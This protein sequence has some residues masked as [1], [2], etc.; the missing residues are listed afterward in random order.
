MTCQSCR[1]FDPH[2]AT[3]SPDFSRKCVTCDSGYYPSNGICV[4]CS[5]TCQQNKC[6]TANGMCMLCI[7]NYVVTSPISTNCIMCSARNKDCVT[8]A[9]NFTQKCVKCKNGK[10]ASNGKCID[11]EST[12]GGTCD[13]VSGYCT[14]CTATYVPSN[15]NLSMCILCQAFDSNCESCV[16]GERKCTKCSTPNMYPDDTSHMCVSCSTTCGGSC[17]AING[18]CTTCQDNYVFQSTKSRVCEQ[19]STF[20]THCNKCSSA[21]ERRC[22]MCNT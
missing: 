2:C 13:G 5:T 15:T 10:F 6:N 21:F 18:I 3:C 16:T 11:C 8:C 1:T 12:C 4:A 19:C 14:G 17:D 9:T 22:V 20:D 7:D